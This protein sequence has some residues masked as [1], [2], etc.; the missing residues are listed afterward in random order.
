MT[1][2]FFLLY[3]HSL[4]LWRS[5]DLSHFSALSLLCFT[6]AS[7]CDDKEKRALA[8]DKVI[9]TGGIVFTALTIIIILSKCVSFRAIF[10]FFFFFFW[11]NLRF[12]LSFH[13]CSYYLFCVDW[14]TTIRKTL[15]NFPEVNRFVI[16]LYAMH[17]EVV[18]LQIKNN[19]SN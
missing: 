17:A 8:W 10:Y 16:F 3:Y 7:K 11:L 12:S 15:L 14:S 1:Q 18:S 2:L 4:I 13:W 6:L 9:K 19:N 5:F